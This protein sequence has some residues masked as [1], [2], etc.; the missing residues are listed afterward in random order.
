MKK[1][2]FIVL[3]FAMISLVAC[4]NTETEKSEDANKQSDELILAVG[5][6]P[7][8]GFDPT[9]GWG[10]YGSPLFQSTLLRYDKI[11]EIQNDLAES[12]QVSDD[13]LTWTVEIRQDVQF[14]DGEQLNA[15]DVVFTFQQTKGSGSVVDLSNVKGIEAVDDYTV[16]FH[17]EKPDST[18]IDLLVTTGI[19]PEHAYDENY[20]EH[21]IGS[22]PYQLVQWDKGQQIIVE[23]NPHYYGK[24]PYFKK[25]TFLFLS[26]DAGYA[27][28]KAG[29]VDVV[30][31]PSSFA[32]EKVPGMKLIQL[33]SVDNRGVMFPFVPS[34]DMTEDGFPIGNDVTADISIRKAINVGVDRKALV[35]GVLDG[36]GT[37]AYSV[38]D[39]L[40][41][42]NPDSVIED[43]DIE[44]AKEILDEGG[45]KE[46]DEGVRV[47]DGKEAAFT[48]FYPADD[49][50]RQSLSMAFA[51]M[52]KPLGISVTTEGKSWNELEQ[53]MYSEPIMMGWGSHDPLEMYN[54]YSSKTRGIGYYNT[55]Y[56]SNEVVDQYMEQALRAT[57][58]EEA[59][60]YWKKAQWDGKEGFSAKGDAPWAWLVNLQ[61]LYL[62][63]EN[64]EIGEQKIQPHGHGWP[65]TD[66]IEDWHW[67]E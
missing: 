23:R 38:A 41:W 63:D 60:E 26:E 6:E 47:K 43:H 61:H 59:N 27:A 7:E 44:Q 14:S 55:N 57:S 56:Y 33:E 66:F 17:L 45:W 22:G 54:L 5:S 48:L 34:G 29:E 30:S 2:S 3:F 4:S 20:R 11:F 51:E 64:L 40:P 10:R 9:T 35:D 53:L 21:P 8:E 15:D 36:Y 32:N 49:Q 37:P 39:R 13:G 42:W 52:M 28:A 58:T 1:L 65:I 31:I 18:F 50:N 24:E 62:I 25:L 12:Y 16:R 67:K 46:T 19:V